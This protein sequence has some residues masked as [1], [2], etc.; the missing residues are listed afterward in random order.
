MPLALFAEAPP[1]LGEIQDGEHPVT[2]AR[3]GR[4]LIIVNFPPCD[5]IDHIKRPHDLKALE[6]GEHLAV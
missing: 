4:S 3:A 2:F 5:H 6:H 1:S